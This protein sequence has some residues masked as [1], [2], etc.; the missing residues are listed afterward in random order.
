VLFLDLNDAVWDSDPPDVDQ[1]KE[2][3]LNVAARQVDEA[4]FANWPRP[5]IRTADD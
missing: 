1:A 5:R 4:S 3:I 2:A